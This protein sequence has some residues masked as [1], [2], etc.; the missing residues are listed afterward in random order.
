MSRLPIA[1]ALLA[2]SLA[3]P[4]AAQ[5][6]FVRE[7]TLGFLAHGRAAD[8]TTSLFAIDRASGIVRHAALNADGSLTWSDPYPSGVSGIAAAALWRSQG[9]TEDRLA[10]TAPDHNRIESP[11]SPSASPRN[12]PASSRSPKPP[13]RTPF[14]TASPSPPSSSP[15]PAWP[16]RRLADPRRR[17]RD[18]QRPGAEAPGRCQ[19]EMLASVRAR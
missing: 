5:S 8:G 9:S 6:S 2:A 10:V 15:T 14:L 4:L 19:N 1:C 18:A 17:H 11:A 13:S 3:S 12:P 16:H 7:S